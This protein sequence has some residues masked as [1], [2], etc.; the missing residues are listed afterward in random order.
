MKRRAI[1]FTVCMLVALSVIF[2]YNDTSHFADSPA[3]KYYI[4]NFKKD[5]FAENAVAA[6]YLNYR[7]FDSI[8]ETLILL[9]SVTAVINFSWRRDDEQ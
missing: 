3:A 8:F 1:V 5:T 4:E 7:M 9:V 2:I 6:I